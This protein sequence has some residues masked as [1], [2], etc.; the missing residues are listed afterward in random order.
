MTTIT[1]ED[2]HYKAI[3]DEVRGANINAKIY[4]LISAYRREARRAEAEEAIEKY[5]KK[6]KKRNIPLNSRL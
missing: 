1:I 3:R 2:K 4:N 6:H 5:V